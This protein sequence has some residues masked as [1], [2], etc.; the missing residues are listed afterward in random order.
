MK[1]ILT[2]K[3]KKYMRDLVGD[4]GQKAHYFKPTSPAVARKYRE[5]RSAKQVEE[6]RQATGLKATAE[7]KARGLLNEPAVK[8]AAQVTQ[9]RKAAGGRK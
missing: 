5:R 9:M 1:K 3:E 4:N 7:R 8:S 2:E 6:M